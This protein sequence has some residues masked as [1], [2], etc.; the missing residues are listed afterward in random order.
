MML[1]G[2]SA[3]AD[4]TVRFERLGLLKQEWAFTWIDG[5]EFRWQVPGTGTNRLE[6]PL[7]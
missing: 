6:D 4:V 7:W 2:A 1:R 3:A 5:R